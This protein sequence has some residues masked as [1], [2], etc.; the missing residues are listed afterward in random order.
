MAL[1]ETTSQ[2]DQEKAR[3]RGWSH[4]SGQSNPNEKLIE[5][6]IVSERESVLMRRDNSRRY[7]YSPNSIDYNIY[8]PLTGT[9]RDGSARK[10]RAERMCKSI[11]IDPVSFHHQNKANGNVLDRGRIIGQ[12]TSGFDTGNQ[13]GQKP[14]IYFKDSNFGWTPNA[15]PSSLVNIQ[16]TLENQTNSFAIHLGNNKQTNQNQTGSP[17]AADLLVLAS[18]REYTHKPNGSM[19]SLPSIQAEYQL[20]RSHIGQPVPPPNTSF[21]TP[22]SSG[23][24]GRPLSLAFPSPSPLNALPSTS[25]V[26]ST[27]SPRVVFNTDLRQQQPQTSTDASELVKEISGLR[28]KHSQATAQNE[29]LRELNKLLL[30]KLM[31]LHRAVNLIDH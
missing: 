3:Q 20:G 9:K 11:E 2:P 8:A 12:L 22:P 24:A 31:H 17:G 10:N 19:S 5:G 18:P 26:G 4:W 28:E 15:T 30:R 13:D 7:G 23:P 27:M 16:Q 6:R 21:I 14:K 25:Y 1:A 29:Q